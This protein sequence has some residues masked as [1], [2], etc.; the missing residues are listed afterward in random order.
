MMLTYQ[1]DI[2]AEL[3]SF[4]Y[5]LVARALVPLLSEKRQGATVVGIHGPW[6]AGKTTLMNALRKELLA[7]LGK[8]KAVCIDFNAWKFQDRGALWRSLILQVL[9]ELRAQAANVPNG[10]AAPDKAKI[11][12]VE[13][14]LYRAFAVEEKGPWKINWRTLIVEVI[15]LL[16]SL[17]KLDFVGRALKGSM[18]WFA[19]LFTWEED[20]KKE[21]EEKA[22]VIDEKR[23]EAIASVL[24]RETVQRQVLQVQSVEQFLG[25]FRDLTEE[26]TG[27]GRRVF[28]FI[29]DLDRCLPESALEIFEAIK[30]FLDAP[31][32]AYVVGLDR[33]V[34]R[35]GLAVRY[36]RQG[37]AALGQTLIDADEYIE[38]TISV[39]FDLPRLAAGDVDVMLV[40]FP[41]PVTLTDGHRRALLASLGTNPRRIKRFLNTLSVQLH[42]AELAKAEGR[43]VDPCLLP[44]GDPDAFHCFL[45]LLLIAYRH[46][47]VFALALEDEG[48]LSRLQGVSN[49]H[50]PGVGAKAIEVRRD[51]E[52]ALKGELLLVQ[53]LHESEEFWR[54]MREPPKFT[55]VKDLVVS[56]QNWFRYRPPVP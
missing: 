10:A 26:F 27:A 43:P 33:E 28:V 47:G 15:S 6:G 55:D 19:R 51:R 11:K 2:P 3:P 17:V 37:E 44:G 50:P 16:L 36:A 48:L 31:G 22:P 13:D 18:G 40:R 42:L 38:K 5:H 21:K 53:R 41:L 35:K 30:L 9:G 49:A 24:E 56:L 23:V 32:C 20:G 1:E 34:I 29:D 39:S 52:Q 46:S 4:D 45:K 14:S 54:L 25:K 12:E 7:A 8:E